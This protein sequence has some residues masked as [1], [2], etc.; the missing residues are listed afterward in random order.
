MKT[1]NKEQLIAFEEDLAERFE[2]GEIN[3]PLHLCG[4]N[5][6]ELISIFENVNPQDYIFSTHRAHYHYLLK[7]GSPQRLLDEVLGKE[8]GMCKGKGRSMHLYDNDINFFTSAIVGG[9]IAIAAGVAMAIKQLTAIASTT[10][11]AETPHVWCFLCDGAEDSGWFVECARLANS[12]ELPI[13]FV[14]EDNDY[15]IDVPKHKRWHNHMPVES[16]NVVRYNYVRT[17]PHVGIGKH[18]S[19]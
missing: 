5:E 13:T 6:A 1:L 16:P 15:S 14:V 12:R 18:V 17:W 7:G 11:I 3:C 4:G 10:P 2:K 8:S 19:F 9:N